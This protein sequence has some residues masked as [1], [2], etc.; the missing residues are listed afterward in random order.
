MV[1]KDKLQFSPPSS[2]AKERQIALALFFFY[3]DFALRDVIFI[4]FLSLSGFL[5]LLVVLLPPPLSLLITRLKGTMEKRQTREKAS[6]NEITKECVLLLL[7]FF[8]WK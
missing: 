2:Q 6:H 5:L 8:T 7:F 4:S 3:S 1:V